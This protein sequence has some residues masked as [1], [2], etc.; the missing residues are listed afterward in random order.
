MQLYH[1]GV[2]HNGEKATVPLCDICIQCYST[3]YLDTVH[4]PQRR[5]SLDLLGE[6][7]VLHQLRARPAR[8]CVSLHA[9][10]HEIA[11][12][13]AARWRKRRYAS[14]RG[15]ANHALAP[16]RLDFALRCFCRGVEWRVRACDEVEQ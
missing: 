13:A 4:S 12:H 3:Q 8:V 10:P 9:S 14:V 6:K 11:D 16:G 15:I 5:C 2:I 7:L 1:Q